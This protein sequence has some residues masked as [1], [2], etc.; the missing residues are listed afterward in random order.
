MQHIDHLRYIDIANNSQCVL[1]ELLLH[2]LTDFSSQIFQ[3]SPSPLN[4]VVVV[5]FLAVLAFITYYGI[6]LARKTEA[7]Q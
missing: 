6:L 3:S 1:R 4:V 2:F 5:L 7:E